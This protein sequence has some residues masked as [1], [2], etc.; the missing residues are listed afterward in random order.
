MWVYQ[1]TEP[2]LYTVGFYAPDGTW[3]TDSDHVDRD[4]ARERVH[5][6]NGGK[7]SLFQPA[8]ENEAE[9]TEEHKIFLRARMASFK[10]SKND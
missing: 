10:D 5:Y 3:H 9:V 8:A 6:I 4:K 7:V 2:F 1:E